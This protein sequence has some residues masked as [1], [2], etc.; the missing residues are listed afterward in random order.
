[1]TDDAAS[2]AMSKAHTSVLKVK[3]EYVPI[4]PAGEIVRMK[5]P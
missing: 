2:M 1:M 4:A 3:L 5:P